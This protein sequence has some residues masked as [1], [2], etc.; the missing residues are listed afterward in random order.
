ML[1]ELHNHVVTELQQNSRT[2][3][4]FVVAAVLFN[5][6]V[7]GINWGVASSA[8]QPGEGSGKDAILVLLI[9]GTLAIN[10]FAARALAAG[11]RTR[12][13]LVGGLLSMYRDQ[14]VDKYYD[15]SLLDNFGARYRLFILVLG[16]LA[17]LAIVVPLIERLSN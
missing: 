17:V 2:D 9:L 6:V 4:V 12:A 10:V 5:L 16:I 15:P 3:T 1:K 8:S 11:R 13:K 7:L 14:G